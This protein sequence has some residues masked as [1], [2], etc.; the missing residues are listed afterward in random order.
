M[1]EAAR[2]DVAEGP[3]SFRMR[4][5]SHASTTAQV[6][7]SVQVISSVSLCSLSRKRKKII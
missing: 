6:S 1:E 2:C 7:G 3:K 5:T 4:C